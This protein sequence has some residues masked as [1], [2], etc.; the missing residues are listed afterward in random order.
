M[1]TFFRRKRVFLFIL[2]LSVF[3]IL[4]KTTYSFANNLTWTTKANMITGRH[5]LGVTTVNDKIYAI[6]GCCSTT[7][8]LDSNEK[9]DPNTDSWV[10][11]SS[12]PTKRVYPGVTTGSDGKIYVVGGFNIT[13]GY[14]NKVEVYDPISDSWSTKSNMPTI[15]SNLGLV[16][17]TNGK[18]Y[19]IGGFNGFTKV[20]TV[21]I[22]DIATDS[23][24]AGTNMSVPRLGLGLVY[25]NNGKIYAIG[26]MNL[27]DTPIATVEEYDVNNDVWSTKSN[28]PTARGYLAAT[29]ASDGKMYAIG[30]RTQ[31]SSSSFSDVVESYDP[32]TDSW[33]NETPMLTARYILGASASANKIYAIGGI[34]ATSNS[35]LTV[36]EAIVIP[37]PQITSINPAEIW[38]GLK[39]SDDVGIKFDLLAEIYKDGNLVTSG[40]LDGVKGGSSG[41]NNAQLHTIPFA[42]FSPVDF[43]QGSSLSLKLY[44]RNTCSGHTHNSGTARLWFNDSAADSHFG[45][46][47]SVNSNNY[48]LL[49]NFILSTVV[50]SGPK[51]K[52]DVGAG[53]PCSP[54]KPFGEWAITP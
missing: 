53:A 6:G 19:A 11:R 38:V 5:G 35:L 18:L 36:E 15:R 45:A 29:L 46:T 17:A 40:E 3:L 20:S 39:N 37:P 27:S 44:V 2:L 54:F 24:T 12:M 21:E 28:M 34:N 22:Y 4:L 7:D 49:D 14:L 8:V 43:P 23:W 30:G 26:G 13:N 50:G 9:Y 33:F 16:S 32:N 48:F 51:G 52:I 10:S 31:P 47:I 1:F 41:F 42:T 25:A